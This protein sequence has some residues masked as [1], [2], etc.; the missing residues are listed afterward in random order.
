MTLGCREPSLIQ[1]AGSAGGCWLPRGR[2]EVVIVDAVVFEDTFSGRVK[3]CGVE[4]DALQGV[5]LHE[6]EDLKAVDRLFERLLQV[7]EIIDLLAIHLFEHELAGVLIA[8][9]VKVR[10]DLRQKDDRGT[11]RFRVLI[12]KIR[13]PERRAPSPILAPTAQKIL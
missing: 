8:D 3:R 9:V 1:T 12:A 11:L 10:H 6:F 5:S 13:E 7:G 4:D 2:K